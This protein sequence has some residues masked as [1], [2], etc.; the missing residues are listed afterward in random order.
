MKV[1]TMT[2]DV[3]VE[4]RWIEIPVVNGMTIR[5]ATERLAEA[6]FRPVAS[7]RRFTEDKG[8]LVGG[9][10]PPEGS[11]LQRTARI[12]LLPAGQEAAV[13]FSD[14]ESGPDLLLDQGVMPDLAG[15][16]G[17]QAISIIEGHGGLHAWPRNTYNDHVDPGF[18]THTEPR[19]GTSVQTNVI[20]IF[21]AEPSPPPDPP[22]DPPTDP[23]TDL[24][25]VLPV[26]TATILDS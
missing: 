11:V 12:D 20:Q 22:T 17:E 2:T 26:G 15:L 8:D 19:A 3:Y 18:V 21:I 25:P 16:S 7:P 6:G 1:A 13:P 10:L 9:T 4:Q 5:E 24:T 23:L 14:E